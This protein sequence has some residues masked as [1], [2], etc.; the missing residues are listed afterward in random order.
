MEI[1]FNGYDLERPTPAPVEFET[2]RA[3]CLVKISNWQGRAMVKEVTKD[4]MA[5]LTEL[6]HSSLTRE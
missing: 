3:G 1:K 6:Q 4:S 2:T 5:S